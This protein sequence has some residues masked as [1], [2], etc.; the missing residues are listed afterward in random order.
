MKKHL[1][2]LLLFAPCLAYAQAPLSYTIKGTMGKQSAPAKIYLTSAGLL[3]DSTALK[4]GAFEFKGTTDFPKQATLIVHRNGKPTLDF[5]NSSNRTDLFLEPGPIVVT[6]PDSLPNAKLTGTQLTADYN[7]LQ[8]SLKPI[9]DKMNALGAEYGKASEAERKT[10]A[11]QERIRTAGQNAFKDVVLRQKEFIKANPTSWVSLSLLPQLGM[12]EPPQ[13]AEVAPLYNALSPTLKNSAPGIQYGKLVQ[14]LKDVAI[15]VQAPNFSQKTPE[16]K[17]VSLADYR[18]KYVLVDFW[19]SWCGPCR[20]ENPAVTK[21]YN[22]FKSKN[23]DVLGVSLDDEKGRAK[24][25]KAIQDDKL[26]WTQVS[27]LRGWENEV[28]RSYHVQAIPQNFLIDP[29]GKIVAANLK[30]EELQATLA[31]LIK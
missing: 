12:M 6:S 1:F 31:R 21:V 24:W 11:F 20:Q 26:A 18:G 29:T 3:M 30:G 16:G 17:V 14:N 13:Y 27:D 5:F 10:P 7:K 28:A 25:L 8:A 15:G 9:T 23:F 19:A 4:N 22:A 2:G